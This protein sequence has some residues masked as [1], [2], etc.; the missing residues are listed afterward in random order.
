MDTRY[1]IWRWAFAGRAMPFAFVDLDAFDRNIAAVR[2]RA[3]GKPVRVASKSVRC[4]G[5]LRRILAVD[6]FRGIMAYTA[7]EAAFLANKGFDDILVAYPVLGEVADSGVLEHIRSGKRIW[8]MADCVEHLR[9][10]DA[11]GRDARVR[12]PVCL[13]VDMSS[14]YPGIYFGVR[15]SPVRTPEQAVELWRAARKLRHVRLEAVMGYEA[16]VA[17]LQ[18]FGAGGFLKNQLIGVLKKSSMR[19]VRARRAAIVAALRDDGCALQLVNGGGT[20]SVEWTA[21]EEA[22]TE[23]TAGSGFF[24]PALFDHY[25]HFRHEP[26][27]GYAIEIVRRPAPG[28]YTC[29]G[30]GYPASGAAGAD[31]L[32]RPWL[33]EG[34]RL[35]ARE[36]AGEVQT[37]VAYDGPER[38]RL[39]DPVFMR[40]AKAG[41]LC[42]R[43]NSLLL[44]EEGVV[45]GE[46]PTYRGEGPCF[47]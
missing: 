34:A 13:D 2:E 26:A 27:A 32:P 35:L 24:A 46:M 15:R 19:E 30:G 23:V 5:L 20:G 4:A 14:E 45:T 11:A 33:P 36:G 3:G 43:F 9:Y 17:G 42:E 6:G 25:A 10:L 12:V 18:D 28:L 40:H 1:K 7:R 21:R 47:L 41:E 37:P 38:L 31:R 29:Q 44:L 22:V 16:Q 39:G 8:L